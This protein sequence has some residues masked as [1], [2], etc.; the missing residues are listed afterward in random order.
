MEIQTGFALNLLNKIL[1]MTICVLFQLR[2]S[3]FYTETLFWLSFL[4]RKKLL[5]FGLTFV[6]TQGLK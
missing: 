1:E 4:S 2:I 6:K 5:Y 3:D